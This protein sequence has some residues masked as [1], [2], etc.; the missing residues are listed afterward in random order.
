[1]AVLG[2]LAGHYSL[3]QFQPAK[4]GWF[5]LVSFRPGHP[6]P[7][8]KGDEVCKSPPKNITSTKIKVLEEV[9]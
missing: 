9:G 1:M 6:T 5:S 2:D 8:C 3:G 4:D 7:G